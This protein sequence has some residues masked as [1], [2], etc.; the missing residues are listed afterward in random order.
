MMMLSL[1]WA[2]TSG[3][4]SE[5]IENED[6][7]EEVISDPK[8]LIDL[9]LHPDESGEIMILMYHSVN[10]VEADWARSVENFNKDLQTLYDQGF[11]PIS[12]LDMIQGNITTEAGY[13]PVVLTFDDG[14]L[15]NFKYRE[16]G[17]ID[18]NCAVGLLMAFHESHPDF[19]LEATFYLTSSNVLFGQAAHIEEKLNQII[20]LGMDLGNHSISHLNFKEISDPLLIQKEIGGMAQ[21]IESYLHADYKVSSMALTYGSRPVGD[22]LMAYMAKGEYNGIAYENL[23]LLKVGSNPSVSPFDKNFDALLLPRIRASEM[24]TDGVGLYDYL[25]SYLTH[26]K[27]R[28]IS[29]GNP[30]VITVPQA[31]TELLSAALEKEIYAY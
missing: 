1:L 26:P 13:T 7:I 8:A 24:N 5:V 30:D 28:Y 29:D 31:K 12:L 14:R 18:P 4:K 9:S 2:C 15:D 21:T 16:D 23:A 17:S 27:R 3:E 20:D 10:E 6:P 22:E 11:R 25:E 19:P